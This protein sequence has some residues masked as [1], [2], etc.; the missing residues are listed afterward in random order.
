F[1]L[2]IL[3]IQ[4]YMAAVLPGIRER[5]DGAVPW[6]CEGAGS[7]TLAMGSRH[8]G[9][10]GSGRQHARRWLPA[11]AGGASARALCRS[12][13]RLVGMGDIFWIG[14]WLGL[15]RPLRRATRIAA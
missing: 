8:L 10:P 6:C 4:S 2:A 11:G 5:C 13:H 15:D 14:V 9:L 7:H 12:R 1:P 3:G